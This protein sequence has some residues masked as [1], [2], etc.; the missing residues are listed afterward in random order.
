MKA[1]VKILRRNG[2]RMAERAIGAD[3]GGRCDMTLVR[4]GDRTEL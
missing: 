2:E 4:E 3:P 1:H